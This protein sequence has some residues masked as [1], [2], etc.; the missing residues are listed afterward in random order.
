MSNKLI[1]LLGILILFFIQSC[2]DTTTTDIQN[3][4]SN[5]EINKVIPTKKDTISD[6]RNNDASEVF[7]L[8]LK[9][10]NSDCEFQKERVQFPLKIISLMEFETND[11]DTSFVSKVEYE[12]MEFT[13]PKSNIIEGHVNLKFNYNQKNVVVITLGVEDTGIHIQYEFKL[14][15]KSWILTKII[16]GS[17]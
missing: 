2:D 13:E 14:I 17:T 7:S 4:V 16:D 15:S 3:N 11:Y 6:L 1:Y 8:F 12:C 9:K 10:F 5:E